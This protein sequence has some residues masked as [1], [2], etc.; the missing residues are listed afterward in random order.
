MFREGRIIIVRAGNSLQVN[1]DIHSIRR[2]NK[3]S[4]EI[5]DL[6]NGLVLNELQNMGQ[7]KTVQNLKPNVPDSYIDLKGKGNYLVVL[8]N[9]D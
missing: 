2:R 5:L 1:N 6:S 3:Y 4:S 7:R 8:L 9:V